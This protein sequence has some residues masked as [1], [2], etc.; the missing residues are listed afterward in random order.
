MKNRN[1]KTYELSAEQVAAV[2][3]L[4]A[5]LSVAETAAAVGVSRETVSR[6][7]NHDA[8][9]IAAI[10]DGLLA[11]RQAGVAKLVEAKTKAIEKLAGLMECGDVSTELKAAAVLAKMDTPKLSESVEPEQ[12]ERNLMMRW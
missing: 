7:R 2:G 8:A 12:V 3:H 1:T 5:G 9:F 4:L 10:N 6:W 11:V